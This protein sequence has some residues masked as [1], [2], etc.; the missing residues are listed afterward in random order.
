MTVNQISVG[1]RPRGSQSLLGLAIL[2]LMG[3]FLAAGPHLVRAQGAGTPT[4]EAIKKETLGQELSA[5]APDRVLLLQRRTFAPGADSGDHPAA[6]PVVLYVEEGEII[7]E[8]V[9]GAALVTRAGA[10]TTEPVAAGSDATLKTGDE[11]SYDQG[12]VH[13]V[14]NAGTVPAVTLEAR[15]NPSEPTVKATPAP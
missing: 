2:L 15:F 6:G 11:V 5:V 4:P 1:S 7:F 3:T 10:T 13:D 8:V 14:Y 9:D 12:V